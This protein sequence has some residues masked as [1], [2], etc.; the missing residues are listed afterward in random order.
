LNNVDT[1]YEIESISS[2][3]AAHPDAPNTHKRSRNQST[4]EIALTRLKVTDDAGGA[5]AQTTTAVHQAGPCTD[6]DSGAASMP[7][8][9][10][11]A[12]EMPL[13][14]LHGVHEYSALL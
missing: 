11:A 13:R 4:L 3:T 6:N 2:C 5:P 7:L 9:R 14:E 12:V 10:M 8:H 1:N